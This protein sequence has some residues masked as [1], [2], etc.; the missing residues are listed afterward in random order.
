MRFKRNCEQEKSSVA[1]NGPMGTVAFC[2]TTWAPARHLLNDAAPLRPTVAQLLRTKHGLG[3]CT[4]PPLRTGSRHAVCPTPGR[5]S[6]SE[7]QSIKGHLRLA[8]A[9][10]TCQGGLEEPRGDHGANM[11]RTEHM[12]SGRTWPLGGS[13]EWGG[14]RR[15]ELFA[16]FP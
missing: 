4:D 10:Q 6:P 8:C 9:A 14:W 11:T 1:T 16:A 13:G 7:K 2:P 5:C 15:P 12:A 3:S